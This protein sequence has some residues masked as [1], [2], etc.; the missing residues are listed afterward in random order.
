M[1]QHSVA[2]YHI[3]RQEG[4]RKKRKATITKTLSA[5][6]QCTDDPG[7][8]IMPTLDNLKRPALIDHITVGINA[9][10]KKLEAQSRVQH[11]VST[12]EP[13]PPT[14]TS[15]L[16]IVFVCVADIQ[17]TALVDHI[18][19]LV[20][21]CNSTAALRKEYNVLPR[22]IKL[23][24]FPPGS[25]TLVAMALGMRRASVFAFDNNAP[26][27]ESILSHVESVAHP[28]FG[29]TFLKSHVKQLRTTAPDKSKQRK[30]KTK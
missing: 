21:S 17:P 12:T 25:D 28:M 15:S 29:A 30:A 6:A 13:I 7:I 8:Q 26:G 24:G 16:A 4:S 22:F 3:S 1:E 9:V 2:Q 20:A 23:V 27:L 19:Q 14:P 11:S 18:P 5:E 10:T